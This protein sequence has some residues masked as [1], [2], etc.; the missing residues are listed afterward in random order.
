MAIKA[1]LSGVLCRPADVRMKLALVT[2]V[3]GHKVNAVLCS[4][5]LVF[6]KSVTGNSGP[7]FSFV[8]KHFPEKA[9]HW[10]PS[11]LL[12]STDKVSPLSLQC[13]P[14]VLRLSMQSLYIVPVFSL[15][16]T[17]VMQSCSAHVHLQDFARMMG[18]PLQKYLTHKQKWQ[19]E[20][21]RRQRTP[22]HVRH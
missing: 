8:R 11:T 9:T 19:E 4:P 22:V 7:R 2:K 13:L 10:A 3:L 12:R 15:L 6:A 14:E 20:H 18:V 17:E 16:L 5:F 1:M 21:R